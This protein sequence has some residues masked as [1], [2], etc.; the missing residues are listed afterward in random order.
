LNGVTIGEFYKGEINPNSHMENINV[1]NYLE[2]L[3]NQIDINTAPFSDRGS[4][5]LVYKNPQQSS[6]YIRIA[7]RLSRFLPK[8]DDYLN[9]P[10]LIRELDLIDEHGELL[11]FE[12]ETYPHVI[13]LHTRLGDFSLAF[14]DTTTLAMGIPPGSAAGLRFDVIPR[15]WRKSDGGGALISVRNL[16]YGST[17]EV[18]QN[19][20]V[21]LADGATRVKIVVQAGDDC[22]I[23]LGFSEKADFQTEFLPFS[24]VYQ[25]AEDRWR[26]WFGNVPPVRE[27]YQRSYAYAWWVM[28]NNLISP[29]GRVE[30]EAMAPSKKSY[31]GLWL[32][33]SA[34]HALAYRYINPILARNQLRAMLACQL[35]DG[36]LPDAV[37]D[38]GVVIE[39]DHPIRAT[40]T[41][42]PIFAW[43]ALKLHELNPDPDFL[44]E[45]YVPL[46]RWNA[47]WFSMNDDDVDGL[48]QYNHPYSSGLDNSPLWDEGMPVESPDLNTYLCVQMGSLALIAEQ[49]GMPAESNMWRR[50]AATIVRRMIKDF[51]DDQ[52]GVFWAKKD[53]QPIRVITPFNLYP[54]WSGQLPLNIRTRL[55]EH[56]RDPKMFGGEFAI[57]TVA[58]SDPKF[59]PAV[60]WR[61]PVWANV[62]YFFIEAL[63]QI[64]EHELA[65]SLREKTL[66][67]I[68]MNNGMYEFY[69]AETGTPPTAAANTFGW[70][71]SVFIDLAIQDSREKED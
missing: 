41:K 12:V 70:T 18:L 44:R 49:L 48:V 59:D 53:E 7:E 9:N 43:T 47:W 14:Q 29:H 21:P 3:R 54:L 25:Q 64:G 31:I 11:N 8:T 60:M 30:Y 15:F 45:I 37:Y 35:P 28:G 34:M 56:L 10:P 2:L 63:R 20:I 19:E 67:L 27:K 13:R 57:P 69:D 6:L 65:R 62:N 32:W 61:G 1:P 16:T 22:A 39:I 46:V 68:R 55:I 36:M 26:A 40:V 17:C 4:R 33:D 23:T 24:K 71:A 42:P 52:A 66:D 38:E 50:R 51:W 58:R 5:L